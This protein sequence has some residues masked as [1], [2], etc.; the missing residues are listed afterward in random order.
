LRRIIRAILTAA[1]V[2]GITVAMIDKPPRPRHHRKVTAPAI[3]AIRDA[4]DCARDLPADHH[5]AGQVIYDRAGHA[6]DRI[7]TALFGKGNP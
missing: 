4:L 1:P 3:A 5:G 7:A 6:L 2:T